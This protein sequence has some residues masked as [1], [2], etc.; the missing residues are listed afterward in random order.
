LT[1]GVNYTPHPNITFRPEVRYDWFSGN[2]RPFND[3]NSKD[4]VLVG[5]N[6]Y[7]QY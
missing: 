2:N 7:V 6:A 3:G 4:Q 1:G 5:I